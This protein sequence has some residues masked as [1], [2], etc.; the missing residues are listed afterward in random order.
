MRIWLRRAWFLAIG[1]LCPGL[2]W[3]SEVRPSIFSNCPPGLP[4]TL[5]T[6]HILRVLG[7]TGLALMFFLACIESALELRQLSQRIRARLHS[8]KRAS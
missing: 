1:L 8:H 4:C 7:M 5:E 2:I 3:D 6:P